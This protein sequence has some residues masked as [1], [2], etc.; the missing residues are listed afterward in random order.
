M[1]RLKIILNFV[2]KQNKRKNSNFFFLDKYIN[3]FGAVKI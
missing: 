2:L 1:K 3:E